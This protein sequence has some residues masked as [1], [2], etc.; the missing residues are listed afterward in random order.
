MVGI[1]DTTTDG[2][3]EEVY[4]SFGTFSKR[5]S[6]DILGICLII[7]GAIAIIISF[8]PWDA[9]HRA[10]IAT[11]VLTGEEQQLLEEH[12]EA[13]ADLRAEDIGQAAPS[14]DMYWNTGTHRYMKVYHQTSPEVCASIMQTNFHIGRGGLCG[15]AIYFAL[16]PEVTKTKAITAN[17]MGG[18]MIEATVDVGKQGNFYWNGG[19]DR[20]FTNSCEGWNKMDAGKLHRKG[21][22]TI[23][24]RQGDGDEIIVFEPE[25]IVSK[26][27]LPFKCEWMCT[28]RCQ[29]HWP[30][31]CRHHR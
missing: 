13:V 12:K 3:G 14:L 8:H 5:R 9:G 10:D 29:Q 30:S 23:V 24:M 19:P 31:N 25:R 28:G 6:K 21:F 1:G 20:R 2:E 7:V 16:S 26:R 18:C 4:P 17:S 15:K 11:D 22:D 27:L